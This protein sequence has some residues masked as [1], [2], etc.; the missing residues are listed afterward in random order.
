MPEFHR[1]SVVLGYRIL[2]EYG[3]GGMSKVYRA[4]SV[5]KKTSNNSKYVIIKII[6]K[7]EPKSKKTKELVDSENQWKKA[8]DEFQI[9][10]SI[11]ENPHKNI[12]KP[13][14]WS[15]NDSLVIIVSEFIEGPILNKFL[16]EN[17]A[18]SVHR[19]LFYFKKICDGVR[20]FHKLNDKV[21][22]IHRDLKPENL[23]LTKDLSEIKIIDYGIATSF[24]DANISSSEETIYCTCD[25]TTPDVL[26][27]KSSIVKSAYEG[28]K[29]SINKMRKI[30]SPQFDFHSLGVILYFMI[31]GTLPFKYDKNST[32]DPEIIRLW[33]KYDLPI[34][35]NSITNVPNSIEN[36]IFRC[37][38]SKPEDK[39]FRY[40]DIDELIND[41]NTWDDPARKD[42]PLL[43][44][45]E[46]RKFQKPLFFNI[47]IEKEREKFY[48]K[49]WFY[50]LI[51]SICLIVI[52]V[53]V[54]I[55]ILYYMNVGGAFGK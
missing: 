3:E 4:E 28:N 42:E 19:A 51:S 27:L 33:L 10:W 23:I 41:L 48:E 55:L 38:A 36:I 50:T 15:S 21:C 17:K 35:S 43:K 52:V 34:I 46:K 13:I 16:E 47:E 45:I 20:H 31:T 18:L 6:E 53:I 9:T 22:V 24:Y 8:I 25:Y 49:W 12:V 54:V 2:D 44:P 37:T 7:P 32:S 29:D 14:K 26:D 11:F 1:G 40:K 39:K 30:I 5:A